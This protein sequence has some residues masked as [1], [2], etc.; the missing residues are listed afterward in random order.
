MI[1]PLTGKAARSVAEATARPSTSGKAPSG[2]RRPWPAPSAGCG[3]SATAPSR[4]P[5]HDRQD[6][7]HPE[8]QR[9][10]PDD[11]AGRHKRCRY[12]AGAG[13]LH[14]FGRRIYTAGANDIRAVEK[15][16]GLTL[17]GAYGDEIATW[18]EELWDMLGTRLSAW[19]APSSSAPAT[20]PARPTGSSATGSTA[21]TY[22][23][24]RRHG[25]TSHAD[26]PIDLHRFSFTLDDNPHLPRT[27]WPPE[28]AVRRPVLQA[29]HPRR[30]GAGRGRDLR[31]VRREAPRHE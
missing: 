14:L 25:S 12:V 29:V 21:P 6:R 15:I 18:P 8:A 9:D 11:R 16:Q 30:V 31:H 1:K 20:R 26:E 7:A 19:P 2:P 3:T 23:L 28:T 10:R 4:Q 24:P 27:S 13:E 22:W 5:R 17:A